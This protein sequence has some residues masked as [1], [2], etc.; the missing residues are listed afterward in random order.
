MSTIPPD[1]APLVSDLLPLCK[2]LGTGAYAVSI[3]G[4]YGKSTFDPASDLDFRLFCERRLGPAEAYEQA[5]SRLQLAVDR[6]ADRGFTVDGCWVRLIDEVNQ[7]IDRWTE[8]QAEPENIVWTIWGY[9]LLTDVY[10]QM[11]IDDPHGILSGWRAKLATYP[12]KLKRALLD[13]HLASLRYWRQD[14]HYRHKVER[15][16]AVFLAGLTSKLVHDML[17]VLFALNETYFPGDGNTLR[18]V[19][20]FEYVPSGFIRRVEAALYP[21]TGSHSFHQQYE[22]VTTLIDDVETLITA[23]THAM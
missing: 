17:Q 6:W 1:I 22:Q 7:E 9:H 19:E 3:G 2:A 8:G 18:Y 21:G 10:N 12:P 4:S 11:V 16:D 14:Y 13:R 23:G 20:T 5:Y 15:S